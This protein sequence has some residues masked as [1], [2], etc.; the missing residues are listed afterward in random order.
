[1]S[2]SYVTNSQNMIQS[3]DRSIDLKNFS[4]DKYRIPVENSKYSMGKMSK[5]SENLT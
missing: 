3:K 4:H 2:R 5:I 1:M